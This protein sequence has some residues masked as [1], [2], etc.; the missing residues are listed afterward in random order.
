MADISQIQ[1]PNGLVFDIMDSVAR[2]SIAS[3]GRDWYGVCST[4][5]NIQT[6][7]V[8]VGDNFVLYTG[9]VITVYFTENQAFSGTV[10]L[11]VN[12]TG[13]I[14]VKLNGNT[15]LGIDGYKAGDMIQ[16]V[17][18]GTYWFVLSGGNNAIT[19]AEIVEIV[20]R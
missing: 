6:K 12:G 20:R 17:Y 5:P 3:G 16:F 11:N 10:K 13:A 19:N 4:S 9:I 15:F 1:L 14:D 18:N 7:V 2:G 8:N